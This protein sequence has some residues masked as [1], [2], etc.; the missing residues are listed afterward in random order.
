MSQIRYLLPLYCS[1]TTCSMKREGGSR[2]VCHHL[3]PRRFPGVIGHSI[4]Q[5]LT[6]V[7]TPHS[8]QATQTTFDKTGASLEWLILRTPTG[9]N[10]G[11]L[12]N[13]KFRLVAS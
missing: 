1:R 10:F 8:P 7:S 3:C 13:I 4:F 2:M 5:S 12:C 9:N 6:P 11:F